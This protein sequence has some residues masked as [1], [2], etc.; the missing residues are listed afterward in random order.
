MGGTEP[1]SDARPRGMAVT[2]D[3]LQG[4]LA[5]QNPAYRPASH[6]CEGQAERDVG[7]A[8]KS[9]RPP[10]EASDIRAQRALVCTR[11]GQED[12]PE[13]EELR[14]QSPSNTLDRNDWAMTAAAMPARMPLDHEMG[15]FLSQNEPD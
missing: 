5:A 10:T 8:V 4:E 2:A 3:A 13:A 14:M 12:G 6:F 11:V 9:E 7:D 1:C 15:G